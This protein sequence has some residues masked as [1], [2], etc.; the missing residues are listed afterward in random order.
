MGSTLVVQKDLSLVAQMVATWVVQL[1]NESDCE[2]VDSKVLV[3]ADCLA[4]RLAFLWVACTAALLVVLKVALKVA[5][6]AKCMVA[7]MVVLLVCAMG[8]TLVV[9]KVFCSVWKKVELTADWKVLHSVDWTA[10]LTE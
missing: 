3:L 7:W 4:V 2:T 9:V 10:E 5:L 6:T 1:A 8:T